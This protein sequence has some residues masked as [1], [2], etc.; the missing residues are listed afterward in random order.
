VG[1]KATFGRSRKQQAKKLVFVRA[2]W[3]RGQRNIRGAAAEG[4]KTWSAGYKNIFRNGRQISP[5]SVIEVR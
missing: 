1:G 4:K 3:Q 5:N 2:G